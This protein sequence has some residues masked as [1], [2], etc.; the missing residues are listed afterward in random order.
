MGNSYQELHEILVLPNVQEIIC[1]LM[2]SFPIR[3]RRSAKLFDRIFPDQVLAE[4]LPKS[5][6][7][8]AAYYGN[9]FTSFQNGDVESAWL[10]LVHGLDPRIVDNVWK[11]PP[12]ETYI[13]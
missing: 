13:F 4:L 5:F 10:M 8:L 3:L 6:E 12:P 1:S 9:P 11:Q 2:P 7:S